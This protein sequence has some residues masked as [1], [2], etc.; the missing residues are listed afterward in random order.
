MLKRSRVA[1]VA[2]Q[3][4]PERT[5]TSLWTDPL[6]RS[7]TRAAQVILLLVIA[8][9]IVYAAV[10]LSLVVI[11][12]IIALILA[13]ALRPVVRFLESVMPR[14]LA[15]ILSLLLGVSVLGGIVTGV[16]FAVRSEYDS[17]E[18]SVLSGIDELVALFENGGLPVNQ[19]VI[20]EA[21]SAGQ[22][23]L[24]SSAFGSGA[25]AGVTSVVSFLTGLV[26][27]LFILF[28]FLKEGPQ[29]WAFLIKAFD[30]ETHTKARNAGNRA[31]EVL[32]G[33]IRG[34]ATVA[35]VDAIIIGAGLFFLDV[36]L[37]LPL[38]VIVFIGAFIPIVGATAAGI[39]A[40]LVALVTNDFNTAVIVIII[41]VVVNQLEGNLL[42][43]F[44]LG[45][46][47]KLN[48]LVVLL[49]LTAGTVLG[50]I[51]GTLLSV[52]LAA[53]AWAIIK[54]WSGENVPVPGI[55]TPKSARG[56]Y[57]SQVADRKSWVSRGR[58]GK[59]GKPGK[60]GKTAKTGKDAVPSGA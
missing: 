17:L 53:V 23:F 33:Y 32:G 35:A 5:P 18:E 41:V 44:V 59:L 48:G 8:S 11:P 6:G 16:V 29:M 9:V 46:A 39:I 55:D 22:D 20:D 49:A 43:P 40:A 52:P 54:S 56:R 10:T 47:L 13:S 28:F 3:I 19:D 38:A 14:T 25:L 45:N 12:V 34:T 24:T 4:E 2:D 60:D 26:L 51:V 30:A 58:I 1:E 42:A 7:A 57:V 50:G 21:I 31:V 15:A 27:F 37:A 36:Q